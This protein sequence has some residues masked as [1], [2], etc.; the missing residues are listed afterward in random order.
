MSSTKDLVD[1]LTSNFSKAD[2]PQAP[3][4]SGADEQNEASE[5]KARKAKTITSAKMLELY[6]TAVDKKQTYN[7]FLYEVV[8]TG[9]YSN[10][11]QAEDR[12]HRFKSFVRRKYDCELET[13]RGTPRLPKDRK[14]VLDTFSCLV[15]KK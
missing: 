11:S 3:G 10:T 12:L 7:E 8:A 5:A 2:A 14:K 1:E 4:T 13:L 15:K 6:Q 9:S